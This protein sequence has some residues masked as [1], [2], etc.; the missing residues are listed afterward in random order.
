VIKKQNT[1]PKANG[2]AHGTRTDAAE[3]E[4][5]A[6]I[7]PELLYRLREQQKLNQMYSDGK[8]DRYRGEYVIFAADTIFAHG[9]N[10][11]KV[12][13]KAEKK[14]QAKGISAEQLVDF[15]VLGQ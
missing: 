13:E 7:G 2:T 5:F 4:D 12:R 6:P 9:R 11:L 10:L 15:F 3:D 1:K 14:A 8:L